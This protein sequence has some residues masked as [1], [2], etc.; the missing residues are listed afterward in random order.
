MSQ[1]DLNKLRNVFRS[2]R[3]LDLSHN[4]FKDLPG[5]PLQNFPS[6]THLNMA[7]NYI[8]ID[9]FDGRPWPLL[10]NANLQVL[11]L[12]YNHIEFIEQS[13]LN[14]LPNLTHLFMNGNRI[15][16]FLS[17]YF[18]NVLK[19]RTISLNYNQ[20]AIM[21][22]SSNLTSISELN[23][24]GNRFSFSFES[25]PFAYVNK[26][27]TTLR[28]G[29]PG[30]IYYPSTFANLRSLR[31]LSLRYISQ[32]VLDRN[33]FSDQILLSELEFKYG[34]LV[35]AAIEN[36]N[37]L[38]SMSLFYLPHLNTL[39]VRRCE[40][41]GNGFLR[42]SFV[43]NLTRVI[44]NKI[45]LRQDFQKFFRL[46]GENS[47][48]FL[49]LSQNM[50]DHV[51][52]FDF[53]HFDKLEVLDLSYNRIKEIKHSNLFS[54][55]Q[56]L[57]CLNLSGNLLR[58][59]SQSFLSS[60]SISYL[61]ISYNLIKRVSPRWHTN[62]FNLKNVDLSN[63]Y[64]RTIS[65]LPSRD[66]YQYLVQ[67]N[68]W[69][70]TCELLNTFSTLNVDVFCHGS[71]DDCLKCKFSQHHSVKSLRNLV[72]ICKNRPKKQNLVLGNVTISVV[73]I[74]TGFAAAFLVLGIFLVRKKIC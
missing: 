15:S 73:C 57:K 4:N 27:L 39:L 19:L 37:M 26:T 10:V 14:G 36:K 56:N 24:I 52:Y 40:R 45:Y 63:N 21:V 68:W 32:S 22:Y 59:L 66:F 16:I 38:R 70:C 54:S 29:R 53:Q 31:I 67:Q 6:M 72:N 58:Y 44:I 20:L 18:Q 74:I 42:L 65:E 12:S 3:R 49:N 13:L 71:V 69:N 33:L 46:E 47:I 9:Y 51:S 11:D 1:F 5:I 8:N 23:L 61:N 30:L 34:D 41:L 17:E 64:I 2:L 43:R 60:S 50:L 62:L 28:V 48:K 25:R 55:F 7:H 35:N